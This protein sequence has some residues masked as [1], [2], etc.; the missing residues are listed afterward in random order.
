MCRQQRSNRIAN[1]KHGTYTGLIQRRNPHSKTQNMGTAPVR[2][3]HD[4]T[5]MTD[6]GSKP[7][8]MTISGVISMSATVC[9]GLLTG[10]LSIC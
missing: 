6:A 10:V 9:G 3:D 4:Y 7:A 8:C 2:S 1:A 5:P